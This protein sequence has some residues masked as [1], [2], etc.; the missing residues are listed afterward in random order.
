MPH[1]LPLWRT[2]GD[3][4][5]AFYGASHDFARGYPFNTEREEYLIHITT[6]T[7]SIAQICMFLLVETRRFP[8]RLL[9]TS[10][11]RGGGSRDALARKRVGEY[12]I[13]DLDLSRYDRLASR[14]GEGASRRD[15][16]LEVEDRDEERVL[17]FADRADRKS[18]AGNPRSAAP[19]RSADRR[20]KIRGWRGRSSSLKKARR[21]LAGELVEVNCATLRGDGAMSTLFGHSKGAF[22]G[23]VNHRP[24]LLRKA[25]GGLL[26]L[27][28][29]GE[30]GLDEQ[31]MLL[32]ALEEKVFYPMGSDKEA[33]SDFQLIAGTNR[34]LARHGRGGKIS[35]RSALANPALDLSFAGASRAAGGH[36][37]EPRIR[38][39]RERESGRREGDCV[40]QGSPRRVP[41]AFATSRARAA[42]REIFATSRPRCGGCLTLSEGG[43]THGAADS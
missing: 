10:P 36:R 26:F 16:A 4:E 6:G 7:A 37:A 23:A 14:F 41:H 22:T 42:G 5:E 1:E 28:E 25:D 40:Q 21:K 27:D 11:P 31:A 30:L 18:G 8:G 34:E 35:R 13:I 17:Q 15:L 29:I 39:G 24:G 38:V 33:R 2:R 20:G 43:R 32:H 9:Q 19:D 12:T 3:S